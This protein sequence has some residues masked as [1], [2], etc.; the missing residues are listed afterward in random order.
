MA[1]SQR[2]L[3]PL[4]VFGRHGG[5]GDLFNAEAVAGHPRDKATR[6]FFKR[7]GLSFDR[8]GFLLVVDYEKT[9]RISGRTKP[10][11]ESTCV[12]LW[13]CQSRD[14]H[15]AALAVSVFIKPA[16]WRVFLLGHWNSFRTL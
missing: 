13:F 4:F 5:G 12:F 9:R 2:A 15:I 16:S 1:G 11:Q 6:E 7:W 10:P 14:C 3:R 8:H